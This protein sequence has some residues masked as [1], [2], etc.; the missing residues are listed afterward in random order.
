MTSKETV[1]MAEDDT[2]NDKLMYTTG[3][4]CIK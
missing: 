4:I 3:K 2:L 1:G